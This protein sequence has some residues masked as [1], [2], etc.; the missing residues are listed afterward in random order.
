[1]AGGGGGPGRGTR[2]GREAGASA[3]AKR[4]R[5]G[6]RG[7]DGHTWDRFARDLVRA[8][9]RVII[10]DLRGHGRSAHSESYLFGEF[11]A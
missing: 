11:G 7:G 5:G 10:P 1:M 4:P 6:G 9:R 8:G 3:E 2:A